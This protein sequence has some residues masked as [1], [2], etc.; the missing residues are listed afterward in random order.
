MAIAGRHEQVFHPVHMRRGLQVKHGATDVI[1]LAGLCRGHDRHGRAACAVHALDQTA[2]GCIQ[3]R[4][5]VG[6][7]A[8]HE[9]AGG[10]LG[11]DTLAHALSPNKGDKA[12]GDSCLKIDL[13]SYNALRLGTVT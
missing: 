2:C 11:M 3:Q 12:K 8:A 7:V 1:K 5:G 6:V 13:E 10:M 4:P 9:E